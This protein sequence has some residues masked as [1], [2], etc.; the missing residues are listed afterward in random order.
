MRMQTRKVVGPDLST[1]ELGSDPSDRF[2]YQ[3]RFVPFILRDDNG[4]PVAT[5]VEESLRARLEQASALNAAPTD[6][7]EYDFRRQYSGRRRGAAILVI[8]E[9]TTRTPPDAPAGPSRPGDD[10]E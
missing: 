9:P 2:V 6:S 5:V 8:A 4:N 7:R 1:L 3:S 10:I